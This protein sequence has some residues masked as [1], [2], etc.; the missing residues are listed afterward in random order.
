MYKTCAY[1]FES[2]FRHIHQALLDPTNQYLLFPDLGLD[3]VRVYRIEPQTG[4]LAEH[5]PIK[6]K[7][8]YGPRHAVFWSPKDA[9][10]ET[11]LFVLHELSNKIVSYS[12]TYLEKGGLTFTEVDEVSTYGKYEIPQGAAAA[13]ITKVGWQFHRYGLHTSCV[14]D[15]P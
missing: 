6:S 11:F 10:S 5:A 15:V 9:P 14:T 12:V 7:T 3:L 1:V 2:L 13:E 4:M 8:G